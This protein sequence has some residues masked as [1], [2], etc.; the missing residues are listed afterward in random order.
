MYRIFTIPF[1]LLCVNR[2]CFGSVGQ[3]LCDR[4]QLKS[5]L[6]KL[7]NQHFRRVCGREEQVVHQNDVAV[8]DIFECSLNGGVFVLV[9]PV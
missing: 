3:K 5:A 7:L 9:L 6:V 4:H 1:V 8:F 2:F